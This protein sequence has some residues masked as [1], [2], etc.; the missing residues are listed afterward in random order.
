[1]VLLVRIW[2]LLR[3]LSCLQPAIRLVFN[4]SETFPLANIDYEL[5][6]GTE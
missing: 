2:I 4:D 6:E 5:L 1:M 3:F